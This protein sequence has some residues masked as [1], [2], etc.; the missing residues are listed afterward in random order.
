MS[1]A[2]SLAEL[3]SFLPETIKQKIFHAY[4]RTK[5]LQQAN[6]KMMTQL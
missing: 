1:L 5:K 2:L 3:R 4:E 6:E